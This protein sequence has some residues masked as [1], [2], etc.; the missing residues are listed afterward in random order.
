MFIGHDAVAVFAVAAVFPLKGP[1]HNVALDA[2]QNF[3][4]HAHI[5][6]WPIDEMPHQNDSTGFENIRYIDMDEVV[7]VDH[8]SY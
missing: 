6:H 3:S 5:V 4:I 1:H 7:A 8:L 2:V